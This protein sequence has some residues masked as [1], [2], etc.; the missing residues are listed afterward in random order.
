MPVKIL[1]WSEYENNLLLQ[2]QS[3]NVNNWSYASSILKRN[4]FNR[5]PHDCEQHWKRV[6][7]PDIQKGRFKEEEDNK[8]RD[9]ILIYGYKDIPLLSE[10]MQT[11]SYLQ[12]RNRIKSLKLDQ[13]IVHRGSTL[14]VEQEQILIAY[15]S[16]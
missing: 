12:I 3:G 2:S 1:I 10:K 13:Q 9:L 15:F 14:T 6:L 8:L 5:S 16:G 11:R 7:N 4:N